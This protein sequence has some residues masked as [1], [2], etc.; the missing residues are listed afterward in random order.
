MNFVELVEMT[1][2]LETTLN[3]LNEKQ[4]GFFKKILEEGNEIEFDI[5][6][7]VDLLVE[8]VQSYQDDEIDIIVEAVDGLDIL[9]ILLEELQKNASDKELVLKESKQ[10]IDDIELDLEIEEESETFTLLSIVTNV[11][12]EMVGEETV[13]NMPAEMVFDIINETKNLDIDIVID[14]MSMIEVVENVST[15][16]K[17]SLQEGLIDFDSSD[18]D[19]ESLKEFLSD[20]SDM[21]DLLEE[22][23][24]VNEEVLSESMDLDAARLL[25][26]SK[27][28][29]SL[30]ETKKTRCNSGDKSCMIK[31]I[32]AAKNYFSKNKT[33]SGHDIAKDFKPG[34]L[35]G[36]L[37]KH[38]S[39]AAAAAKKRKFSYPPGY[40]QFIMV[41][42]LLN[43]MGHKGG[44][45]SSSDRM[46][47]N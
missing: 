35:T 36:K 29:M 26:K 16:I 22:M 39:A 6:H 40:F 28:A 43:K 7:S 9:T 3:V 18:Y 23:K 25:L 4:I 37:K 33:R 38:I 46:V 27:Q 5:L 30:I 41:P 15:Q 34:K 44:H 31:K 14:D 20:Y 11:L 19:C 13:E 8:Y 17:T 24:Q 45:I 1:E 42:A 2:Q 47:K 21:D 10:R 32:K 12:T